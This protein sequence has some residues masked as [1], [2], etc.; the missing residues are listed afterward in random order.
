MTKWGG[1]LLFNV[2]LLIAKLYID[3]LVGHQ[4]NMSDKKGSQAD[5]RKSIL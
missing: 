4:S 1:G 5:V 2:E 3:Q